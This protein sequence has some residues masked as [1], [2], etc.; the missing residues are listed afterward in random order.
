MCII[1]RRHKLCPTGWLWPT[2]NFELTQLQLQLQSYTL[3]QKIVLRGVMQCCRLVGTR[4]R[5]V[6]SFDRNCRRLMCGER[7]CGS[8]FQTTGRYSRPILFMYMLLC[9]IIIR[10]RPVTES[11][12][13]PE[14]ITSWYLSEKMRWLAIRVSNV[15]VKPVYVT[16]EPVKQPPQQQTTTNIIHDWYY[17]S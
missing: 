13:F 9:R 12:S 5:W 3:Q 8:A 10:G 17:V 6:F 4:K 16:C 14:Y 2:S 15:K 11:P 1:S 7:S